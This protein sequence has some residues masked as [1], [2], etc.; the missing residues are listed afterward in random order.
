[1]TIAAQTHMGPVEL[2]VADLDRTVAYW[3]DEIGLRLLERANGRA[4]LGTDTELLRFV[5]EPGA[6]PAT[7]HTGLFHVAL[8]VPDRPS[9]ARWLAHAARDRTALAGLSDHAVSEA[10]YLRDPDHH[11]IEIY[12][13]RPRAQ[14][15]GRVGE[16]MTTEPLDVESLFSELDDPATEPFDGLPN[17]TVVGHTHLCVADVDSTVAFYR[18]TLGFDVMAHLGPA[19][20]FLSAGGYHHHVGAN[21]WESRGADPAPPGTARLLQA[22]IVLPDAAERDR[23]AALVAD[24]GQEPES[25]EDGVVVRDPSGNALLL[26]A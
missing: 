1:M 13:D 11:G 21:T 18:D 12:A 17:G 23:V 4:S 26:T 2:S 25:Q 14:W 15:E 24:A 3:R 10:I 9:L 5:E 7:G 19:A 6:Q 8:L 16:L 22:A 20:A